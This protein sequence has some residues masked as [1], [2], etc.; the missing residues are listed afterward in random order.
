MTST[1]LTGVANEDVSSIVNDADY[2][3]SA[4]KGDVQDEEKFHDI[5]T[6]IA[7]VTAMSQTTL[8]IQKRREL[9]KVD[10]KLT[11]VKNNYDERM[12]L[13]FDRQRRFEKKQGDMKG[14]VNKFEKF[15]RENN[16]KYQRATQKEKNEGKTRL[17]HEKNILRLKNELS[18]SE[19]EREGRKKQLEKVLKYQDYLES[20]LL[21]SQN[22]YDEVSYSIHYY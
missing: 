22:I 3:F 17:E 2:T 19:N 4:R 8:L 21:R 15:I 16:H 12:Q 18:I 20:V 14:Q 13:C 7:G 6:R 5:Q 11:T 9:T 1:F 10:T